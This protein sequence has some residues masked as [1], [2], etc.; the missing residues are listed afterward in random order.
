M[1]HKVNSISRFNITS[2]ALGLAFLYLPTHRNRLK[3]LLFGTLFFIGLR[4]LGSLP[5]LGLIVQTEIRPCAVEI[6]HPAG[7][8]KE[9]QHPSDADPSAEEPAPFSTHDAADEHQSLAA[10]A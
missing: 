8:Q 5:L 1:A 10:V 6:N 9:Q 7:A 4:G 2:L 3:P